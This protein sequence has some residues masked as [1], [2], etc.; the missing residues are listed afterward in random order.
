MATAFLDEDDVRESTVFS[1]DAPAIL[2]E[3]REL[4]LSITELSMDQGENNFQQLAAV[5]P[6]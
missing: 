3:E 1:D 4:V 2:T 5:L 6:T